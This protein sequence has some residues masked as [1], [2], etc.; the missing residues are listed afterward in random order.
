MSLICKSALELVAKASVKEGSTALEAGS[1]VTG[2]DEGSGRER[3][4]QRRRS[5]PTPRNLS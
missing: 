4:M 3:S 2:S 5:K 1:I